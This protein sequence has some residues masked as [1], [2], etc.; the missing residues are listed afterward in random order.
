MWHCFSL[1]HI[2]RQNSVD[3]YLS[4]EKE[5]GEIMYISLIHHF[6]KDS[7]ANIINHFSEIKH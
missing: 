6:Q 2:N 4:Y 7:C 5:I 1:S 3:T